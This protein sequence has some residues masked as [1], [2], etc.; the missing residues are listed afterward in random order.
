VKKEKS[1]GIMHSFPKRVKG[2]ATSDCGMAAGALCYRTWEVSRI[3]SERG[4]YAGDA[5]LAMSR[6][7]RVGFRDLVAL[8]LLLAFVFIFGMTVM[9][10]LGFTIAPLLLGAPGQPVSHGIE[11]SLFLMMVVTSFPVGGLIGGLIWV[12]VMA[13]VLRRDTVLRLLY[14]GPQLPVLTELCV[15]VLDAVSGHGRGS[16]T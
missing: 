1:G 8:V 6:E 10:L 15:S 4:A 13:L 11:I 5:F 3:R 16:E 9:L 2:I 12:A 14:L 7:R